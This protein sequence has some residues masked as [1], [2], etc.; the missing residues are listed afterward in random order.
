MVV[1]RNACLPAKPQQEYKQHKA[2][3][4]MLRRSGN[5][6][7]PPCQ[8]TLPTNDNDMILL[9]ST[10]KSV[11]AGAFMWL[12]ESLTA[13]ATQVAILLSS[14]A[15]VAPRQ[16]AMLQAYAHLNTSMASFETPLPATLAH[17]LAWN[18]VQPG[19]CKA[20]LP[21]AILPTL[22]IGNKVVGH[23]RS[24]DTVTF[25]WDGAAQAAAARSGKPLF[26]GWVNQ[27]DVPAYTPLDAS[28]DGS[29][30][31]VVPPQLSGTAFA[32]LT[33]QPDLIDVDQLTEATLAGPVV[34]SLV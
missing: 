1:E 18:Y 30:T 7:I 13:D 12:S 19:S 28:G 8:Y 2:L 11:E 21:M 9:R 24:N 29:G 15:S 14:I 26:I 6:D 22:S 17:S 27:V 4:D 5:A 3:A 33:T 32:V 16:N 31:T 10:L 20:E 23:A 34:I 25:S